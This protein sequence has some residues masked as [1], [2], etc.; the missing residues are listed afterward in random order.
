MSE[1][2]TDK[3]TGRATAND[4]TVTVGATATQSLEQGL[5]KAW[6]DKPTDGASINDSFNVSSLDDD[7][8]GQFGV[9]V[10][11]AFS[12]AS[13][14]PTATCV[15]G[16]STGLFNCLVETKTSSGLEAITIYVTA[17]VNRTY[18]DR[19]AYLAVDGD[20]A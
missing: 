14:A 20:L 12:S 10:T 13:Y 7:G 5:A 17:S 6:I 16:S 11:N 8:T 19:Q 2:I 15:N 3:L 4:V 9:N 18:L 1:V